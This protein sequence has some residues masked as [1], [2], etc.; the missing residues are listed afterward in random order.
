MKKNKSDEIISELV[1]HNILYIALFIK[2]FKSILSKSVDLIFVDLPYNMTLDKIL[3]RPNGDVF[4]GVNDE[5]D[6]YESLESYDKECSIWLK[7]S[8]RILKDNG[9]LWVIG[10]FQNIHRLGYLLQDLGCWI[11]NEIV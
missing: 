3:K 6:K 1:V 9:S 10:S 7:E 5:W 8:L 11:I 2:I 4:S